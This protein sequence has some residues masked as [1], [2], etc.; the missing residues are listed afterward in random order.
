MYIRSLQKGN[1]ETFRTLEMGING[2]RLTEII[3][4]P[5]RTLLRSSRTCRDAAL[6]RLDAFLSL[7]FPHSSRATDDIG[8]RLARSLTSPF[9]YVT[10]VARATP[11]Y[12]ERLSI[13]IIRLE[14]S[15]PRQR[16]GIVNLITRQLPL[17]HSRTNQDTIASE[18]LPPRLSRFALPLGGYQSERDI[19]GIRNLHRGDTTENNEHSG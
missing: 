6:L 15:R 5:L 17:R 14:Q 2:N 1:R 3:S 10:R 13:R 12:H 11:D 18:A 4:E 7:C 9:F 19:F 16:D 8:G